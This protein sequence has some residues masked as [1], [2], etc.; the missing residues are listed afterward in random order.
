MATETPTS[1][2]GTCILWLNKVMRSVLDCVQAECEQ[3]AKQ[4]TEPTKHLELTDYVITFNKLKSSLIG[5]QRHM[6]LSEISDELSLN[7]ASGSILAV[8]IVFY[9]C[10]VDIDLSDISLQETVGF[11][12]SVENLNLVKE[13]CDKF[14]S[15]KPFCFNF[16]DFLYSPHAMKINKLAFIAEL[17]YLFEVQPISNLVRSNHFDLFKDY[18]KRQLN[19]I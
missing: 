9:T 17:F 6:Y 3:Y 14:F 15:T 5:C 10:D 18:I 19:N 2:E 4:V 8:L 11:E 13:F 12:E 16:E 7:L 1:L